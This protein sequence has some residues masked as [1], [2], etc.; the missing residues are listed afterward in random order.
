[1]VPIFL[2]SL[3]EASHLITVLL[4]IL[5]DDLLLSQLHHLHEVVDEYGYGQ[6]QDKHAAHDGPSADDLAGSGLRHPLRLREQAP[7]ESRRDG[8]E[9]GVGLVS[10]LNSS[11]LLLPVS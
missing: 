10:L 3:P 1:M 9:G 8:G 2:F 4:C 11:P 7:P 5:F 6:C